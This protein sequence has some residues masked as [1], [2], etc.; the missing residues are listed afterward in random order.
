MLVGLGRVWRGASSAP[1]TPL[2]AWGW[3]GDRHKK[4]KSLPVSIR[5]MVVSVSLLYGGQSDLI[6]FKSIADDIA[7]LLSGSRAQG[8]R[9][10]NSCL[11]LNVGAARSFKDEE[12]GNRLWELSKGSP[13]GEARLEPSL[14]T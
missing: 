12:R 1:P 10:I 8:E 4:H 6:A 13:R 5:L 9:E 3:A 11:V 7:L 14:L 2:K